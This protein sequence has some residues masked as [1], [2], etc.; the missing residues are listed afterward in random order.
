[1][2]I[3]PYPGGAARENDSGCPGTRGPEAIPKQGE[4]TMGKEDL[5]NHPGP[6]L[7]AP[8]CSPRLLESRSDKTG[9]ILEASFP[10]FL[11]ETS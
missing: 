10:V 4:L 1:M 3:L 2:S 7:Q 6:Q 5:G 8:S 9:K 11:P